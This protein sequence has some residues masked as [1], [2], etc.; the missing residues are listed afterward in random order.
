MTWAGWVIVAGIVLG[1]GFRL[2][3]RR[4]SAA[5]GRAETYECTDCN[6]RDCECRKSDS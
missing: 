3:H 5:G 1:V 4:R 2:L 6:D